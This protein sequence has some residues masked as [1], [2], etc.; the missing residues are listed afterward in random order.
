[1]TDAPHLTHTA[2]ALK[3]LG[4][5]HRRYIAV[6]GARVETSGEIRVYLDTLPIGG[7]NGFLHLLPEGM[8]PPDVN[9]QRPAAASDDG[10]NNEEGDDI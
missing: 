5:R 4:K 7:F 10:D 3:V 8:P 6:G 9:P 1:M 2:Y